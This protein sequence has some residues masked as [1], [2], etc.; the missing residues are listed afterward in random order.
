[1]TPLV[2]SLPA[3]VPF[4][5][6]ETQERSRGRTF[7]ARLGANE[8]GFGPAPS[9][10]AAIAAGAGEAWMYGDPESHALRNAIATYHGVPPDAVIVGE[11]IDGLLGVLIRLLIGPADSVVTSDGAYPTFNYHVVGFGG[12][13]HRVLY[14]DDYED[15]EALAQKAQETEA[16]AVYFAN[17]DNP[18]G[19]WHHADTVLQLRATL[20]E[21][22]LLILDEAYVEF[23]PDR[24]SPPIDVTDR[25]VIRLRTF[26]KAHGLAGMR[27]GYALGH[28]DLIAA[29]HKVRN[30]FGLSRLSQIAALAS[31]ADQEALAATVRKVAHARARI[32]EIGNRHGL[33]AIPSAANFVALDCGGDGGF[34][35]AVLEALVA[36]DVFVRMPGA[37]GL[38]RCIR[39]SCGP[40]A[41]LDVFAEALPKALD[42]AR[43]R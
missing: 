20:P 5:G 9:V 30:H 24:T 25:Q 16:K 35:R 2:H 33:T 23:A 17:P 10:L 32:A 15:P 4:V 22:C 11:G 19:T 1:M 43:G 7:R 12:V 31:L 41:E 36:Q 42:A 6:P 34:A 26:S 40:D 8:S 3:T 27:V 39:V 29:F 38:D 21:D 18:M 13:L 14:R 37:T 28:P